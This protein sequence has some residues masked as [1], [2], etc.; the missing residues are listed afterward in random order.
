MKHTTEEII[1]I[2]LLCA[3]LEFTEGVWHELEQINRAKYYKHDLKRR[4]KNAKDQVSTSLDK[5]QDF[6]DAGDTEIIN[7]VVQHMHK[8]TF[9][10]MFMDREERQR[11]VEFAENQIAEKQE[12][13]TAKQKQLT[14]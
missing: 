4:I 10:S 14:P 12:R 3:G 5:V 11:V 7:D 2:N 1:N 8:I 9:L 13:L 6:Y